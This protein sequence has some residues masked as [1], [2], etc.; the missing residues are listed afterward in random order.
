MKNSLYNKNK[1][2]ILYNYYISFIYIEID[3]LILKMLLKSIIKI[4]ILIWNCLIIF[5][6]LKIY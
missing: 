3:I 5:Y 2:N 1:T 6:Q 4:K